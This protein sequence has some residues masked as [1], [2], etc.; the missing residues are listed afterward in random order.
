MVVSIGSVRFASLPRVI[1]DQSVFHMDIYVTQAV[2][3]FVITVFMCLKLHNRI[4]YA[5]FRSII[6]QH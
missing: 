6:V 4:V 3:R 5:G 1:D 2:F